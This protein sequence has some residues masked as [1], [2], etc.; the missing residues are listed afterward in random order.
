MKKTQINLLCDDLDLIC[1]NCGKVEAE[2]MV[3]FL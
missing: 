3:L 2:V 1:F